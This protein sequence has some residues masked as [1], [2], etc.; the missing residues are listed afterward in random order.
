MLSTAAMAP[1]RSPQVVF[2]TRDPVVHE[3]SGST[4]YILGLLELLRSQGATVSVVTTTAYSRSPRL[5]FRALVCLPAGVTL[6]APGYLRFGRWYVRLWQPRAWVRL[7]ARVAVRWPRLHGLGRVVGRLFGDGLYTG[8]WDLTSPTPGECAAA[9]SAVQQAGATAVVANYCVWGPLLQSGRLGASRTAILMHDLLSARV[10]R[11][12]QSGTPLD[13]PPL[14]EDQEMRWLSGADVVLAAQQREAA[15]IAP[16][17]RGQVLVTPVVLR[18]RTLPEHDVVSGRCLF[19]GSNIAPNQAALRFLLEAVWPR[20]RNAVPG[21][22]LAIAG[23]VS[24]SLP[25]R[26]TLG[27]SRGV[28]SLGMVPSLETEYRRAAVCLVPLLFGT[29]IKIKLLEALGFGKAV[30]STSVGVEGLG[31]WA[32]EAVAVADDAESF[33]AAI[34]ALLTDAARRRTQEQAARHLAEAHFGPAQPLDPAFTA[35]L[36]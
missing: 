35:A 34:A 25:P 6:C 30:V 31:S 15:A 14:G 13:M 1:V 4:T 2:L 10:E 18:S 11:F 21:A 36:L 9:V 22:T 12:R 26:D 33:A 5:F 29:G 27:A 8:A 3:Q 23:T 16:R 7:G 17:V 19:V 28:E 20:V 24:R 32:A